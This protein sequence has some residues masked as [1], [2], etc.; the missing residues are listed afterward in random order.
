M[1]STYINKNTG[2]PAKLD[3]ILNAGYRIGYQGFL[4]RNLDSNDIK[5]KTGYPAKLYLILNAGYQIGKGHATSD[6]FMVKSVFS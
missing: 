4:C 5:K 3:L 6:R 2:Y 1:D